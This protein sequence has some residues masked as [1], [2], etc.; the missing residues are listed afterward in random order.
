MRI[1]YLSL[2][3]LSLHFC[4]IA[5]TLPVGLLSNVEDAY[6]REQLLGKDT[7]QSSYMIRPIFF[8][9]RNNVA[10]DPDSSK[11]SLYNFRKLLY[12]NPKLKAEVYALPVVWQQ[13]LNSHHPFG[14]N[15]GSM[16]QANGYQTQ[17]SAGIY[18][19]VGPLSIQLRPEYVYAENKHFSTLQGSNTA[20]EFKNADFI[21]QNFIDNPE[22][23][24]TKSYSKLNW[25]QSSIRLDF[26]PISVG[27]SNENLWWGP[28]VHNALLMTNNA[29]GFK[30]VTLNTTRPVDIYIGKIE[31]Q[32]VGGRLDAS[33][34]GV[35]GTN[36]FLSYEP[37]PDDWRYFSGI[38]FTYQ[39]KWVPGLFLGFDR[40]FIVYRQDM[41][42]T[43]GD[44]LPFLSSVEKAGK[45]ESASSVEDQKRRDQYISFFGRYVM[46]E[47]HSELYVQWGRN[48]HSYNLR[49]FFTKPEHTRAYVAGFRKLIPLKR[50][51]E[52]IQ[53]GVEVTQMEK[54][55]VESRTEYIGP[56]A[57]YAHYQVRDG[58]TNLGQV[59]GAGIGPGSNSQT[60]DVSWV[61]G[62]KRIGFTFD[63][64]VRNNDLYWVSKTS[65]SRRHWVDAAIKGHFS[66][67][68]KQLVL[69]SEMTYIHSFNYHYGLI[70]DP[71]AFA[72]DW[73]HQDAQNF[74]LKVGLLYKF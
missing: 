42:N 11:Y 73:E 66:W 71:N 20:S 33:G 8:N 21:F 7:S 70:Q 56:L 16:I 3:M 26:D 2:L 22:R 64:I 62:L 69:N 68:F 72:W 9:G 31:A 39:P 12:S 67:D 43:L 34:I 41:G 51:N 1:I 37:K 30:H 24:G 65:D 13:Q 54:P 55:P 58:Y 17:V 35:D 19:K 5:Q 60:L 32:I 4:A 44:Y 28:G 61:K 15:D 48:D 52:Y 18:A 47:S 38:A 25:G 45:D 23:Y 27:I 10:L 40:S 57:W 74:H 46:P 50:S 29:S 59:L 49:D 14:M 6:R 63:R 53:L 36:A